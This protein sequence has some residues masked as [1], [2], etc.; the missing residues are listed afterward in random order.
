MDKYINKGIDKYINKG[1]DKYI[2]K[3][4]NKYIYKGNEIWIKQIDINTKHKGN[5]INIREWYIGKGNNI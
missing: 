1:M 5:D 3:R 2:N 4:M